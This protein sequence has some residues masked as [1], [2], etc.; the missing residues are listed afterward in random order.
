MF[1]VIL[2]V[3]GISGNIVVCIIYFKVKKKLIFDFFILNLVVLDFLFCMFGIFLEIV[4]FSLF[5]MFNVLVVCSVGR[6]LELCIV[7]VLVL[8]LVFIFI[9]WYKW[10]CNLGESFKILI[11]KI[12]CVVGLCIGIVLLLLFLVV[13]GK[14]IINFG[15]FGIEGVGCEILDD[16]KYIIFIFV[17]YIVMLIFFIVGLVFV[18]FVYVCIFVFLRRIRSMRIRYIEES[19]NSNKILIMGI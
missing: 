12:M 4:D 7:M 3:V 8:I 16:M 15:F 14:R 17:F 5:Y 18:I 1:F 6:I 11:V 9:D 19:N 2:M 10:I 13:M